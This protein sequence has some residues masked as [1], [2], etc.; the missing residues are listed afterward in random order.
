MRDASLHVRD[1]FL[2]VERM[3]LGTE[4]D[5]EEEQGANIF[6]IVPKLVFCRDNVFIPRRISTN[7]CYM[8]RQ[9]LEAPSLTFQTR[10]AKKARFRA[11]EQCH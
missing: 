11:L 8:A 3:A 4:C 5:H 2:K 10:R 1:G 9:V 6:T 7:E